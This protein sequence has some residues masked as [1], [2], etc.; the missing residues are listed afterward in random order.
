MLTI[1]NP[2]I[3]KL[4]N[5]SRLIC[6]TSIDGLEKQIY[7]EV[8]EQYEKYLCYERGDAFIIGLLS[9]AMRNK[10]DI[11]SC[12]P[13]TEELLYNLNEYLIPSLTK[14]DKRLYPVK[15]IAPIE[16]E[17]IS[18]AGGIGTGVSGGIDS[19]HAILNNTNKKYKSLQLTHLCINSV[20]SF[21][22]GYAKYGISKAKKDIYERAQRIA[23]ELHLPLIESN[24]NIKEQFEIYFEYAHTYY[25]VFAIYCMQ[26][27][28]KTYFY[29]SSGRDFSAFNLKNNSTKSSALYE[30]L[31]LPCFSTK[32]LRIYSEG[33]TKTRIEKTKDIADNPIVQKYLHVCCTNGNNCNWC[34]KCKRTI[35]TLDA[36]GKLNDFR[37]V[38]NIEY[39]K[40]NKQEYLKWLYKEHIFD[41][42]MHDAIYE[43]YKKEINMFIKLEY[44]MNYYFRYLFK[45]YKN[46][47]HRVY[48][49]F[50]IKISIKK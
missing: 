4:K 23:D 45:V 32:N 24:S 14:Y 11:Y 10:Q 38:F 47:G 49:I 17:A 37:D 21:H 7:F 29:G 15:I 48:E 18:N 9:W 13:I 1:K 26:K 25:S 5:K 34:L 30:L 16:T 3:E 31:S 6:N 50:G 36:L 42:K 46:N 27:L 39:Y 35:L 12:A 20:G 44:W 28:W 8:N 2:F 41:G 33:A 40:K 43:Y 22:K 19:F